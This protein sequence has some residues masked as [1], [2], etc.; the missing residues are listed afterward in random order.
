MININ[1]LG[2]RN[3]NDSPNSELALINKKKITC[4]LVNFAVPVNHEKNQRKQNN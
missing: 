3:T 1:S 2:H 4:H